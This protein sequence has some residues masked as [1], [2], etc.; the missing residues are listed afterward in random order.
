M[1]RY[2]SATPADRAEML[3]T[4]GVESSAEL[5]E[6]VPEPLRLGRPLALP[7]GMSEAEVYERLAALAARNADAEAQVCFLGA[8]MYDHYVPAIVDA[9]IQR[10]EFL[11]PY[12]PYQ[13]EISQGGLQAM[14]EFQT[15]MSELTALPVSNAGLYEGPSSVASAGYLAIGATKGRKR[16][17]VS[18]G[19]HPHSRETLATYAVGYGAEIAEV[20]LED[21]LT[22]AA[23]LAE[24]VDAETAAVFLQSPN[25]LGAVERVEALGAAAKENGALL[26]VA[27]DP[28]TLGVLKPP[29]EC[30][31]DIAL[32][33]GQPLG[34]RLDFG[35]PSFG[36]FCATEE[37]IRR[38]PGRIAGETDDIDGRRGFVLALQT[39]E[40]HIRREK[41]THN[42]C[43]A[44]ALNALGAMV[45]LA[46]LGREGFRELGEL[47]IRRTAYAR[48]RLAAVEGVELL[49]GAPVAREF[50]IRL[51]APVGRV[52]ER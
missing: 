5:F 19:V 29:G 30:G 42:I 14:F 31:A 26:V 51:E 22:D 34:N 6:Q 38:M 45:H 23:A 2:T 10:S 4:I 33:E 49:H 17:V 12:T 37:Q 24:A 43:T 3:A 25:F 28:M 21:G 16:F 47:L 18:R 35:G 9:I 27:C 52:L 7:D 13:P 11:T 41:A 32:G 50:A 36:F 39:R 40:Q 44:Q 46:W 48:E 8:G 15:A 1:T 20:G